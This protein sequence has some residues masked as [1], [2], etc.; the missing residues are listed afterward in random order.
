MRLWCSKDPLDVCLVAGDLRSSARIVPTEPARQ[1][2]GRDAS[3]RSPV[4]GDLEREAQAPDQ[5]IRER[6][7]HLAL[8]RVYDLGQQIGQVPHNATR[9]CWLRRRECSH[10]APP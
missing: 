3:G 2:R 6:H 8:D 1:D 5:D 10:L 7:R 4:I 9:E